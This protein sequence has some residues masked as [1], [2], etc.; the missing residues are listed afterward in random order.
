MGRYVAKAV[1]I[2]AI[3]LIAAGGVIG[4]EET[5]KAAKPARA[6]R[7]RNRATTRP[8]YLDKEHAPKG[9][10]WIA[11]FDGKD[12]DGW[13][14]FPEDRPN[15]WKVKDGILTSTFK[16]GGHGSNIATEKKFKDFE[17]YYEYRVPKN[18][19]SGVFLR[20][21]Y[22]IQVIDDHGVPAEKPKDWGNGGIYGQKA[23]S[24]NAS[25]PLGEWQANYAKI[26]GKKI[27]V[28]VNGEKVID[29]FEPPK[30]THL[31]GELGVKDGDPTGPI[32]LQG[33]HKPIEYRYV[34]IKPIEE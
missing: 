20:G 3:S 9:K 5:E 7:G 8:A 25:K 14:S 28:F 34:M 18:G 11:L 19:N 13:K 17:I 15:S 24:K 31:Y 23:P 6:A 16:E 33:D 12:L 10:G 29:E 27:T 32:L 22:E 30:A 21:Q 1:A 2:L 26:V 4:A